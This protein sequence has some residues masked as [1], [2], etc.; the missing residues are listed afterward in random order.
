MAADQGRFTGRSGPRATS[1]PRRRRSGGH[2]LDLRTLAFALTDRGHTLESACDAF[3]VP[4]TKRKVEHGTITSEYIDY[5]REDVRATA[6]L[7]AA[8][9][10]EYVRH[11]IELQATK[12]YSPAS[13]RKADL[14]AMG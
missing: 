7:W 1:R 13:I 8:A 3:G 4:Y 14:R 12:A 2:L 10:T 9:M 6:Q 5:N 11:P